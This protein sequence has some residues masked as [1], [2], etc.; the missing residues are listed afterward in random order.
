MSAGVSAKER[1]YGIADRED[2]GETITRQGCRIGQVSKDERG[3]WIPVT[4]TDQES[5]G[6]RCER[7][8]RENHSKA[9]LALTRLG[10]YDI[11]R[12]QINL[13]NRGINREPKA[14]RASANHINAEYT[15]H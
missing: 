15:S 8:T 7:D 12:V 13:L 10:A 2:E 5:D 4:R 3:R 14:F 9:G 1:I 11:G 6:C